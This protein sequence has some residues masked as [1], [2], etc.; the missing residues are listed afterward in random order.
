MSVKNAEAKGALYP[1]IARPLYQQL[2]DMLI[3]QIESGELSP[4][5][6]LPGERTLAEL[7]DVSRIT[8]RK[9]IG[10]LVE[11]GYLIRS[12]GRETTVAQ[13]KVDHHLGRLVGSIEEFL[14]A[15]S[16]EATID[17]LE[18]GYQRGSA[19]VRQHLQLGELDRLPVYAFARRINKNGQP[20]AI[21]YSFVPYEIGKFVDTLDLTSAKVF[22]SLENAG[23]NLAYGEQ[24]ISADVCQRDVAS[25]LKYKAGQAL[26]VI[27]RTTY[28]ES[29]YPIL[30][31][32]TVYRSD[33]YQYSI[34]LQRKI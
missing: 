21:N 8:V 31:E 15:D 5:D 33:Q 12:H 24:V 29:G 34:R 28:L 30:Y 1:N 18:K 32:K 20:V 16:I 25:L 13:R 14:S 10:T 3:G 27:R 26:L 4:G 9:C 6:T 2:R 11:D 23:Y 7:Y 19:S 22:V 17:V